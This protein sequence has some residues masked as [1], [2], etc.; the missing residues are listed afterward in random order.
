MLELT[1]TLVMTRKYENGAVGSFTHC[2][3]LQGHNYACE[4]E[5]I[6]DGYT[7]KYAATFCIISV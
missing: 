4:L 7:M 6:A 2:V 5:V 3:A 1:L